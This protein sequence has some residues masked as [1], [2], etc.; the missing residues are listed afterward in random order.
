VDA[1]ENRLDDREVKDNSSLPLF[2]IWA[3]WLLRNEA[4]SREEGD[5]SRYVSEAS[6]SL[7]ELQNVNE[8]KTK[9]ANSNFPI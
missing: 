4:F 1:L 9:K 6:T 8:S 3:V 7:L 2:V 5:S